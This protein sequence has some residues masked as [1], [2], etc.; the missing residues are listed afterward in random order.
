MT[1]QDEL[2]AAARA[3]ARLA[4]T[5]TSRLTD[6]EL[7]SAL[8]ARATVLD[9][10]RQI[11]RDL[12]GGAPAR[13][14][15]PLA[16]LEAHPVRALHRAL[17]THQ[18]VPARMAPTD[19]LSVDPSTRS[20]RL[21]KDVTRHALQAHHLWQTG[22]LGTLTPEVAWA[23]V[24]DAATLGSVVAELDA[25]L[26]LAAQALPGRQQHADKLAKAVTSGLRSAAR[27]VA[28]LA[29]SGPLAATGPEP[30]PATR[31]EI[32][33]V[34]SPRHAVRA[35]QQLASMLRS[36]AHLRPERVALITL[37]HQRT[38]TALL[39]GWRQAGTVVRPELLQEVCHHEDLLARATGR[40]WRAASVSAGDP[41]PL[42]QAHLL[43]QELQA[44]RPV[45][46]A[47]LTDPRL[48]AELI[49][50][51][52]DTSAALCET[53]Q[54]HLSRHAWLHPTHD[55][56]ALVWVPTTS[57]QDIPATTRALH[58][59]SIHSEVLR[60]AVRGESG[61]IDGLLST[62]QP[63]RE[64]LP[65]RRTPSARHALAP[66]PLVPLLPSTAVKRP[67]HPGVPPRPA[68]PTYTI[69][70]MRR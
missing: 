8:Y 52:A 67:L 31:R 11:C 65:V 29:A 54:A 60:Q 2:S 38:V 58:A 12:T 27:E 53:T 40:R 59:A 22:T 25:E 63:G 9:I 14:D 35:Q 36:A 30:R 18:P 64:R 24:V 32:V 43:R 39:D 70:Q 49:D 61:R 69:R 41:Y 44:G 57:A 47:L 17:R 46:T 19:V 28:L 16:E 51:L 56:D 37:G 42:H 3:L 21:W 4:V 10:A 6:H 15:P 1:F 20:G 66:A 33:P 23:A 68:A 7:D 13:L 62:P 48:T 45:L 50:A 26:A 34:L 55:G 5:G